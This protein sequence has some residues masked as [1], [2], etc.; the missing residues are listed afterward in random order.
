MPRSTLAVVAVVLVAAT[1]AAAR[2]STTALLRIQTDGVVVGSPGSFRCAGRC[3]IPF[4]RGTLVTVHALR[5][6]NFAFSHWTGACVGTSRTCALALDRAQSI[7]V[8]YEGNEQTVELTVGGPGI[9]RSKPEGLVC[10]RGHDYACSATFPFG[11]RLKLIADSGRGT[12]ARWGAAC[13]N[14]GRGACRLTIRQDT[15]VIAAFGHRGSVAEPQVLTVETLGPRVRSK[16]SGIDCPGVCKASFP[17]GT[18]VLLRSEGDWGGDCVGDVTSRCPLLLDGATRVVVRRDLPHS[19]GGKATQ[20][21]GVNVTVSGKGTVT[22]PGIRCGGV[23]GSLFDC[24]SFFDLKQTVVLRAKPAKH[25]RFAGW[26][27][28]CTGKKPT[29]TLHVAASMTVGA[30]FRR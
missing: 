26:S 22:A 3:A 14:A 27:Q 25:A 8:V 6:A 17:A 21:Y 7:R 12:L 9:V 10:G 24:E 30:A 29:C 13:W 4:E 20:G 18:P 28:F 16:P 5:R 2:P 11:T 23:S 19:Q 1:G 15:Q